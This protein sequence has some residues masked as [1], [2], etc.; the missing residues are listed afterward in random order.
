MRL[1]E[2]D[3]A[4]RHFERDGIVACGVMAA[5]A[6]VVR[7]GQPDAAAGIVAGGLLMAVSYGAIKGGVNL[8]V[9]VAAKAGLKPRPTE[10]S[11]DASHR[12]GLEPRLS[13]EDSR[14]A[15]LQPRLTED[16]REPLPTPAL[17]PRRR[18]AAALKFFTRYALLAVGAYVMLTCFRLHPAGLLVGA[19]SPFVAA[20]A[21]VVR[22][23][24][25]TARQDHP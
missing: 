4:L 23:F 15:G 20:A 9:D 14:G 13:E 22:M 12:A 6:L 7:R 10:D 24:R 2:P 18:A 19:M 3:A 1:A 5:V 21:Q 17:S 8:V 16:G 11:D 25:A